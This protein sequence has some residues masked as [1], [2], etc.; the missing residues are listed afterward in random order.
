MQIQ[1]KIT[2]NTHP[3]QYQAYQ[4]QAFKTYLTVIL[5]LKKEELNVKHGVVDVVSK[6]NTTKNGQ[7]FL[8]VRII[9][10]HP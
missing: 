2:S 8:K 5:N 6:F 3:Y 7:S 1:S 10:K 4:Y 9:S